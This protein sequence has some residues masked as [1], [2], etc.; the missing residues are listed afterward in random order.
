MRVKKTPRFAGKKTPPPT[1]TLE[2]RRK[3]GPKRLYI[4]KGMSIAY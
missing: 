2:V 3:L 4:L 1:P